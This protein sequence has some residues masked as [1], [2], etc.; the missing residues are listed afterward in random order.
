MGRATQLLQTVQVSAEERV[1]AEVERL[2][3]RPDNID[4]ETW[5]LIQENGRLSTERLNEILRSPRFMRLRAGDQAKLIGLAQN[6][7]YGMPQTNRAD[8]GKRKGQVGDVVAA[9]LR[10]LVERTTLPEYKMTKATIEIDDA[11]EL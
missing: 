10:N 11:E 7:A 6:R 1:E 5:A 2:D 3:H 4:A 8:A 9:E